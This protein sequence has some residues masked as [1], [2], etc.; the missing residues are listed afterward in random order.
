MLAPAVFLPLAAVLSEDQLLSWG[1]RVPFLLSAVVVVVGLV[2]RLRLEETPEFRAEEPQD[3]V[4][5]A[6]LG[7]LFRDHWPDVL[8]VF[9]AAFI[10]MV[11]TMFQVFA[12][13]FA[14]SDDYGIGFSNTFMLWLAIVANIVAIATI[15]F[16]AT[17]LGPGRPQA[18]VR[19]R[20]CSAA[21]CSSPPS[22]APSPPAAAC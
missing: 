19:H 15:P 3:E 5:K 14:T 13:N 22:W 17:A 11:N 6:P 4:A 12:L 18:G 21:P 8:R 2:I 16:W 10:A 7:V 9:F 1:W 20:A